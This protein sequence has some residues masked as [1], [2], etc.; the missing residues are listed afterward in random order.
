VIVERIGPG[1]EVEESVELANTTADIQS[2][3]VGYFALLSGPLTVGGL[4]DFLTDTDRYRVDRVSYTAEFVDEG[5]RILS[6]NVEIQAASDQQLW[7]R[8]IAVRQPD[9]GS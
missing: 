4:D 7:L 2:R 3:I 6:P 5:L 1:L 8:S 9:T